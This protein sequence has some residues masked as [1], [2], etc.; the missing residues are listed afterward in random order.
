MSFR[1]EDIWGMS[2]SLLAIAGGL[3]ALIEGYGLPR[4]PDTEIEWCRQAGICP[5]EILREEA[6]ARLWSGE[7]AGPDEAVAVYRALLAGDP[8]RPANWAALGEALAAAG[9]DA[10]AKAAFDI[11]VRQ[12]PHRPEILM[13]VTNW[14]FETGRLELAAELT[15]RN[16][17]LVRS[18]DQVLFRFLRLA[19]L[20]VQESLARAVPE[21]REPLAA[22]LQ[23]AIRAEGSS[24]ARAVWAKMMSLGL[25]E[26]NDLPSYTAK[27]LEDGWTQEAV[28]AQQNVAGDRDP[29]WPQSNR[30]FNGSFESES[31]R[32]PLDWRM[33]RHKGAELSFDEEVAAKGTRSARIRFPGGENLQATPLTQTIPVESS[34]HYTLTAM[35]R[36]DGVT[37]DEG[38]RIEVRAPGG[39]GAPDVT[40]SLTGTFDWRSVEL[41]FRAPADAETVVVSILRRRS[42]R[43]NSKIKGTVW[44]DDFRVVQR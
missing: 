16:L 37:T 6:R 7:P 25:V 14:A 34:A 31:L 12:G 13:Q 19:G 23:T 2:L 22:F 30:V 29:E 3:G 38:L 21:E 4:D 32:T 40:E 10:A 41:P 17:S 36:A 24:S 35:V 27:L 5:A 28:D 43:I 44:I 20:S 42:G 15:K 11:A 8:A 9:D 33:R 1:F 26:P 18:Y 39:R